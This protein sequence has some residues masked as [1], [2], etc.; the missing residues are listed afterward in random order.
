MNRES[1]FYIF[2]VVFGRIKMQPCDRSHNK[3][4]IGKHK[5]FYKGKLCI[6]QDDKQ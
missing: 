3:R 5:I 2:H 1:V 6:I 4:T